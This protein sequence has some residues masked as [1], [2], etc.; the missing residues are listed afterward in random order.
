MTTKQQYTDPLFEPEEI[1]DIVDEFDVVIDQKPRSEADRFPKQF[2][3]VNAFIIN[4]HNELWIPRRSADKKLFPLALDMSTSGAVSSGE[5]YET[6]FKRE[7]YE[8]VGLNADAI[9]YTFLGY[10]NPHIHDVSL[11]MHVYQIKSDVV[12][13]YNTNDF[14]EYFWLTPRELVNRI[15]AGEAA[16]TDLIKLV[17]I[18][19]KHL[20]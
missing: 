6:A 1:L 5:D 15:E 3:A 2:R 16:K 18:F 19:Y 20:L 4:S 14:I 7:L 11:F 13:P 9:T 8:E 10:L 17:K 12:P